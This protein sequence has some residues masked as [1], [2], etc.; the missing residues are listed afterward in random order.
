MKKINPPIP[1]WTA[2]PPENRRVRINIINAVILGF[3]FF[4]AFFQLFV[5]Y[6]FLEQCFVPCK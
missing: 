2:T 4:I 3:I 1:S 6:L 5:N